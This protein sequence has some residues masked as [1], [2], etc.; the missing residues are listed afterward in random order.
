M[1]SNNVAVVILR[2]GEAI[3]CLSFP[4]LTIPASEQVPFQA[5]YKVECL[6]GGGH[7]KEMVKE[8]TRVTLSQ[9]EDAALSAGRQGK[10]EQGAGNR[11]QR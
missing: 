6:Q 8:R 10:P 11:L 7:R 1:L 3:L 2:V 9:E 5:A 4:L